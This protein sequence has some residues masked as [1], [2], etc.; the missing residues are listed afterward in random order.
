MYKRV[1]ILQ[2]F[3]SWGHVKNCKF[4]QEKTCP[5]FASDKILLFGSSKKQKNVI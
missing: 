3:A 2:K 4:L 5:Y 1:P